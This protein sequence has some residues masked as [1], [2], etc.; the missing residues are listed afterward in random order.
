MRNSEHF[1]FEVGTQH[2]A[3]TDSPPDEDALS[4]ISSQ[5]WPLL[6]QRLARVDIEETRDASRVVFGF[7]NGA[8]LTLWQEPDADDNLLI[9]TERPS[10]AWYTVL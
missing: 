8:R 5:I 7:Q 3:T 1:R 4:A 2:N 6:G 9:V 10:G